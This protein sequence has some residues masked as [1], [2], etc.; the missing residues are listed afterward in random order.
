MQ[1]ASE[2]T[3]RVLITHTTT[4]KTQEQH[5]QA[6]LLGFPFIIEE[7]FSRD[8]VLMQIKERITDMVAN[9]EIVTLHAPALS[10]TANGSSDELAIQGWGDRGIFKND[11]DALQIF[12]DIEQERNR[13]LVGGE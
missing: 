4:T 10:V 12:D 1:L 11:P 9:A 2:Q 5:W 7:A 13:H 6:T 8:Q 3:Y